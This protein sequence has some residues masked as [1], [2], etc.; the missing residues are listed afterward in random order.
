MIPAFS[1]PIPA[2]SDSGRIARNFDTAPGRLI[3]SP[4][5]SPSLRRNVG[6]LRRGSPKRALCGGGRPPA[7]YAY[8]STTFRLVPR[9]S[10]GLGAA[11]GFRPER[12]RYLHAAGAR[13]PRRQLE[14]AAAVRPRRAR[15]HGAARPGPCPLWGERRDYTWYI[16][17]GFFVRSPLK[18]NGATVGEGD[19]RKYEADF[20][21][22]EQ[23]REKRAKDGSEAADPPARAA[24]APTTRP[25]ISTA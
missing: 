11:V 25:A 23:A 21:R 16:R 3:C 8:E 7:R 22:R 15:N 24:R 10:P 1:R 2:P 9:S 13:P 5:A 17:D 4:C 18:V 20:L 6:E 12:P 14:E 19:R